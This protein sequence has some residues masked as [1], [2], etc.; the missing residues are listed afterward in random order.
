VENLSAP[1][2]GVVASASSEL[3]RGDFLPRNQAGRSD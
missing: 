3:A 2:Q 1:R